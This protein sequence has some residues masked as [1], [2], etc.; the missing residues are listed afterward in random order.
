MLKKS[1]TTQ[2]HDQ[3]GQSRKIV[4]FQKIAAKNDDLPSIIFMGI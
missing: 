3:Q 2:I 1:F 4:N